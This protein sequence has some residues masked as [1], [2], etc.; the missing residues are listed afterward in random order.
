MNIAAMDT[1]DKLLVMTGILLV[2]LSF[3][4]CNKTEIDQEKPSILLSASETSPANCDTLWIGEP[5]VLNMVF[6]DNVSLGAYTVDLHHNFDHHSHSTET[7]LCTFDP[8][9]QPINPYL[10][11]RDFSIPEGLQ[12]YQ[13][14]DTMMIPGSS[15]QGDWDEG[16]YH[17]SVS[18]TDREGWSTYKAFHVKLFRRSP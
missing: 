1:Q 6:T 4:G 14:N 2:F 12:W 3:Q 17:L 18:V 7:V 9:K 5:F 16:D 8:Q 15:Q 11:I 10:L 13:C